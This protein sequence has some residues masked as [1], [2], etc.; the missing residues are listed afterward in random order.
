MT[1]TLLFVV[2]ICALSL[3]L[4]CTQHPHTAINSSTNTVADIDGNV[5]HTVTIGSQTWTVENLRTTKYNDGTPIPLVTDNVAWGDLITPGCCWYKNG[6]VNDTVMPISEVRNM[7]CMSSIKNFNSNYGILY[8][9]YAVNTGK[10]APDGW[11]VPTVAEWEIM[12]NY[13]VQNG[14]NWDG[15]T[16]HNKIARSLAAK[17]DW[18]SSDIMHIVL[19]DGKIGEDLSIN[20][21]SGFSALPSGL[22]KWNGYFTGIGRTCLW[23][24]ATEKD[25]TRAFHQ[26][27]GFYDNALFF[28]YDNKES[29]LSV[30][31]VKN[32]NTATILQENA[33]KII[34][35]KINKPNTFAASLNTE[36]EIAVDADKNIYNTVK[37]GTQTW[38]IENLRTTKFN[39]GT[40]IP[41]VTDSA[42][43]T[44]RTTP[45]YC[46]YNNTAHVDSINKF[47][48]LYNWYAVDAKKLAPCG[49]H[50]PTSAE[51]DTLMNYLITHGYNWDET[52]FGNK[53]AQSMS[54]K[55]D[56]GMSLVPIGSIGE[57]LT[58]NNKSG[59]SALPGGGR[60]NG[61]FNGVGGYGTW[62]SATMNNEQG[63]YYCS[64]NYKESFLTFSEGYK[65]CGF[66]VRLVK[67]NV[68]TRISN[69]S[70]PQQHCKIL[71]VIST[72]DSAHIPLKGILVLLK[73]GL[74]D[75]FTYTDTV[76][77]Y[78]FE[79]GDISRYKTWTLHAKDVDSIA[80]GVYKSKD[81]TVTVYFDSS[82]VSE[83]GTWHYT[84]KTVVNLNLDPQ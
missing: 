29:G 72:S 32:T 31:L 74:F 61:M 59:F 16:S 66:S 5:Y 62:W 54:A 41:L 43:W 55:S 9:W 24:S 56:W 73:G 4:N 23:W 69:S 50:I 60:G 27:L 67:D 57:D 26:Q 65:N 71:G 8:N 48:A 15:T 42:A 45:G 83:Y 17:I 51:W 53:I 70:P 30:R 3:L 58:M 1:R 20:N 49:W 18:C 52:I 25:V 33:T 12:R 10:L 36:N 84:G 35:N 22:R 11:H 76:G 6:V 63:A 28:V 38:T 37:I 13:L 47:G 79:Q 68:V 77:C 21:K 81:T 64:L 2:G 78:S 46:Y 75:S 40:P 82:F 39:D 19:R 34:D 14:Y 80:N 44:N 7:P